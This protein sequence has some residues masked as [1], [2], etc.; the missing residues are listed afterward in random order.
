MDPLLDMAFLA[1]SD[2]FA[3]MIYR[4]VEE[5]L[6]RETEGDGAG[7]GAGHAGADDLDFVLG[8]RGT[9]GVLAHCFDGRRWYG[10]GIGREG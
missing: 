6:K 1:E 10:G 7:A 8:V 4:A 9:G 2:G 5:T 3:A